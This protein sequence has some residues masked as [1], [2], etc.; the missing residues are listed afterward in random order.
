MD[1]ADESRLEAEHIHAIQALANEHNCPVEEINNIYA[2]V[3]ISLGS[4]AR[5]KDYL[6]V[7]ASKKVRD[8]LHR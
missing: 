1:D 2:S 4:S 5:I 3:L 7:L 6:I 8:V